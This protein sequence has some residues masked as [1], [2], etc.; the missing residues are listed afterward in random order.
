MA[1][2]PAARIPPGIHAAG[3]YERLAGERLAAPLAA[4]VAGGS[5]DDRTLAANRHAFDDWQVW[6][7]V[8]GD[9]RSLDLGR[10]LPGAALAHPIGLAPLAHQGLLHDGGE[11]ETARGAAAT[12]TLVVASTLSTQSMEAIAD[13]AGNAPRWFQL[14]LQPTP[15]ATT[16]LV[17]RAENAG[18]TA[19][20]LTLDATVQWPSRRALQAGFR[21]PA[22]AVNGNFAVATGAAHRADVVDLG[23]PAAPAALAAATVPR[24]GL[25]ALLAA[26]P[27]WDDVDTLLASTSLPVYAK[28][29]LHADDATALVQRGVTGIV[30]GNHGGRTL[31]G[32]PAA[33]AALPGV[34]AAVGPRVPLLLDGGV[35]SGSDAF[36][37]LALGA[38]AVL[39]GRLQAWALATA[40]ALGVAHCLRLLREELEATM[41]VAGCVSVAD[42]GPACL[43][44]ANPVIEP[45]RRC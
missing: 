32:V 18:Y 45:D 44:R 4:Y 7:R 27:R 30:V 38:D 35:R 20:V 9:V 41:A 19:L 31:D 28:G 8:L 10:A 40:G 23:D 6:P 12:D 5:G 16:A 43:R 1:E 25:Q 34:R 22:D 14:Y 36:K 29:V 17:R 42:I 21:L 2:S 11:R 37:A 13:A 24:T 15:A 39:V 3:D 26:A 33:L